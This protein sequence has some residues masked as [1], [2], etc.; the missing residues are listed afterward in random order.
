[1]IKIK[2][3]KVEIEKELIL[4]G[5]NLNMASGEV[6]ALMGPNGSGKSTLAK[7]LAGDSEYEVLEGE[8]LYEVNFKDQ[9]LLDMEVSDRA[10][11][12][13][14]MAFQ[15]PIEI[16]GLNN[17]EFLKTAFQSVCRH[18][19]VKLMED[20]EF[21]TFAISKAR[22]LKVDEEFLERDLNAGFSGGEKKQNEILQMMILS[23]KFSILDESD[24]GLDVDSIQKIAR[25]INQFRSKNRSL[26]LITH[27]HKLLDLVRPDYV[28][29]I[30]DGQIKKTG[31]FSLAEKI[32]AEGYDWLSNT[33]N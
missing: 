1:M 14:F 9:D 13:V 32:E 29:I 3:L 4:N 24:S 7:V 25:G 15:Y 2:N 17:L 8:V 5:L 30:I 11:E 12:G 23:P 20:E 19:G 27:Y 26:L 18:Q 22:E 28:H 33:K 10:K 21:K 6:H 31:D 16:P